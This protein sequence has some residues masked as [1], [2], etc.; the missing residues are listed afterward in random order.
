M[1]GVACRIHLHAQP[2]ELVADTLAQH[3]IVFADTGGEDQHVQAAE[4]GHQRTD[5]AHDAAYV[6]RERRLYADVVHFLVEQHARVRR[7]AR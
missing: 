6:E 2:F 5:L 7:D 1:P 4:Y 3:R